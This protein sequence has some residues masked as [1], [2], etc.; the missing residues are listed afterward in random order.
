MQQMKLKIVM[1]R[2]FHLY[3][4]HLANLR[5]REHLQHQVNHWYLQHP[6]LADSAVLDDSL[7]QSVRLE[8]EAAKKALSHQ[9]N[10]NLIGCFR[11]LPLVLAR[12]FW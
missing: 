12:T 11:N 8:A 5:F 3:P 4:L 9:S 6:L 10:Y 7:A 2:Y 1:Q